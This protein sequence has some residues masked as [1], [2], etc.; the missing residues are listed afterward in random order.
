MSGLFNGESGSLYVIIVAISQVYSAY[1]RVKYLSRGKS[2]Y[3]LI[4]DQNRFGRDIRS[5]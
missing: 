1:G 3:I 2:L 5:F 4:R